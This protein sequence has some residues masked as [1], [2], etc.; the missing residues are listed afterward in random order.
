M[1]TTEAL[2]R[3]RLI[4]PMMRKDVET[5]DLSSLVM[6]AANNTIPKGLEGTFTPFTNIYLAGQ[7]ALTLKLAMD[8][9]RIFDLSE[10]R[11]AEAQ[12][13]A[14]I[15]VLAALLTRPDVRDGLLQDAAKWI[16][17]IEI[18]HPAGSPPPDVLEADPEST[19]EGHRS[20]FGDACQ[21]AITDFLSLA[22]GLE[23]K[24]S[25]ENAALVRI[26]QFRNR[27]LAHSLFDQ[28]PDVMPKYAD[29]DPLAE[30]RE[31]NRQT[32]LAGRRRA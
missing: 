6:E 8:L 16:A 7:N 20:R 9:A 29:L 26:R 19:K 21:R 4:T 11:P 31:R 30:H 17:G 13:K 12:D 3:I 23:V 2:R 28:E 24:D 32:R 5:A 14:S 22:K 27:R 15:P 1:D 25:D 18:G 10:G